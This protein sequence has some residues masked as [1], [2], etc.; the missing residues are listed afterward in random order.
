MEDKHMTK[1]IISIVSV[2]LI[3]FPFSSTLLGTYQQ[4]TFPG[5]QEITDD[6]IDAVK[7]NDIVAIEE[8]LSKERK[9][10]MDNPKKKIAEFLQTMEGEII[11]AEY[12]SSAREKD[13]SGGGY[14]YS[15]RSWIIEF[16][17]TEETYWLFVNWVRA[18]TREPDKVGMSSMF[19]TDTE[20]EILAELYS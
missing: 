2:L 14:V 7:S 6:I 1:I 16:E 18:D 20:H 9:K 8:M 10:N 4:L 15:F 11:N 3:L 17:T 12:K 19:F 5:V 13:E